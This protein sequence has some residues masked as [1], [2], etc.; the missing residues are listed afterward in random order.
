VGNFSPIT[1]S[2]LGF[3]HGAASVS[4]KGLPPD[5]TLV[6]VDRRRMPAAPFNQVSTNTVIRFVDLKRDPADSN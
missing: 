1:T 3:S 5:D 6:L 2:G 4:F